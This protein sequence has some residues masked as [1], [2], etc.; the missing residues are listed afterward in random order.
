LNLQTV[1]PS[2]WDGRLRSEWSR[3][4]DGASEPSIFLSPEWVGA[5]QRHFG[6]GR[7]ALLVTA[8][9][10][11]GGLAGVAPLSLRRQGAAFLRGP[12]VLCFLGDEG[13]GS[14][15]LGVLAQK[16]A[17]G[18]FLEALGRH[19]QG[20]WSLVDLRGLREGPVCTD[21]LIRTFG[22]GAPGRIHRERH[23]CSFIPLPNDYETYLASLP[24]KFRTTVRYRTNKLVKNHQVRVVRTQQEEEIEGHLQ[25][26]F[27]L[28]QGRWE[29]EGHPG[30]FYH[31]RKRAFY[32]DIS[33][34]FLRRGWLRFYHLEV[35][36]VIRAAQFGFAFGGVLHS[37]QEAFDIHF[38][39]P[40][41]GGVGVVLRGMAIR[42]CID[43]G[44]KAYDF[45]GG[46]EEFK[47]RWGTT[48]H[49]VQRSRIGAPGPLGALAYVC[50]AELRDS[51]I[52]IRA[53]LPQ[54]VVQARD[55]WRVRWRARTARRVA[56]R[57]QRS[58]EDSAG[59]DR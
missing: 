27:E 20:T 21:L 56:R 35:D 14:E 53:H 41:V 37:L 51:K 24:T 5:W 29:A 44:L 40:G 19:V 57:D 52:W 18:E 12:W 30:S 54:P 31:P 9:D 10:E 49:Y 3:L 46:D 28:H 7:K 34:A 36:G 55:R 38:R 8:R 59:V 45:L 16:G 39:P 58:T 32:H 17:E 23:P 48:T 47:T 13:V 11:S 33:T 4:L 6:D 42:A 26:L 43:E 1:P 22:S 15:Y 25:R 50:S 2:D